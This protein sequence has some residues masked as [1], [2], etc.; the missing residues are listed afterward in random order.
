LGQYGGAMFAKHLTRKNLLAAGVA[1]AALLLVAAADAAAPRIA[2]TMP[3]LP[4]YSWTGCYAG[5]NL[6][7]GWSHQDL[8]ETFGTA[9]GP[10]SSST[11]RETSGGLFGGQVGC[12]YELSGNWVIG[13]QGDFSGTSIV[14]R[15][16]DPGNSF[17]GST[18]GDTFGVRANWLASVTGRVGFAPWSGQTLFYAKAGPAWVRDNW[19]LS[20]TQLGFLLASL[21]E[22][23]IGWTVGGGIER[24]LW[25]NWS[26]FVDFNY[27][28]FS[29]GTNFVATIPI[30]YGY[31][32]GHQQ[33]EAVEV[34]VN[35]RLGGP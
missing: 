10:T 21:D 18:P 33:I 31:Q 29:H 35:Y 25:Q 32:T 5:A 13:A 22:T 24:A 4:V 30:P 16:S 17:T 34:G 7:W 14:G 11:G 20:Q 23:R 6:G 26:V 19:D 8:T 12:D 28:D 27:Y 1:P 2:R 3:T 15:G 9:I